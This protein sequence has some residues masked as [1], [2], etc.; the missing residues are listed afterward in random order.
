MRRA[1]GAEVRPQPRRKTLPSHRI[2]PQKT[3]SRVLNS[4]SNFAAAIAFLGHAKNYDRYSVEYTAL[5]LGALVSYARP[6]KDGE[7][8]VLGRAL[9]E[10]PIFLDAAVD[11]GLIWSFI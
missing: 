7:G 2:D 9:H 10:I 4:S 11:L 5:L 3:L 1:N 6:F 8:S